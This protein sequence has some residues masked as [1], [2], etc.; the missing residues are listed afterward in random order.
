MLE[1]GPSR[2]MYEETPEHLHHLYPHPLTSEIS[3]TV[4][5]V[6]VH[7]TTVF[8]VPLREK[9]QLFELKL[10]FSSPILRGVDNLAFSLC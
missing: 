10:I 4:V 5:Q 2:A 8:V 6:P 3:Q 7:I 9:H 1:I